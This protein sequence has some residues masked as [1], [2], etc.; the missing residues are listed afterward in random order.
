[1]PVFSYFH[2][3]LTFDISRD[4]TVTTFYGTMNRIENGWIGSRFAGLLCLPLAT[5]KSDDPSSNISKIVVNVKLQE[6]HSMFP[7]YWM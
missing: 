1:M 4:T 5:N 2:L 7:L 6:C 3:S